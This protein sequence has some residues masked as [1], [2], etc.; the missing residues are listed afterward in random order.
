M[1]LRRV[2][3]AVFEDGLVSLLLE[4]DVWLLCLVRAPTTGVH[5]ISWTLIPGTIPS[6]PHMRVKN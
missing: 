3:G 4:V 6:H 2:A 5:G 1:L